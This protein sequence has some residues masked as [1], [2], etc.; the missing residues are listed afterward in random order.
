VAHAHAHG[1]SHAPARFDKAF[2]IGI[3]LNLLYVGLEASFGLIAGSLVL[4]ADAGHNLS[5]V[6]G[7]V[8]AWG[9]AWLS[10]QRLTRRRTY[11]Y[12]RS[13]ILAA[14]ANAVLL[15]LAVGAIAWE[16]VR[17]L[18]EP[19]PVESGTILWVAAVGVRPGHRRRDPRRH[20]GAAAGFGEP[21]A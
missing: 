12:R 13:S 18:Q 2:A 1:H 19:Q 20:L 6:L 10:R 11:G 21:V 14:L 3:A 8:L 15:L 4:L 17:R 16:A 7:L 5:D 9:A